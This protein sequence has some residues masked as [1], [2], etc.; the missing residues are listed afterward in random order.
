MGILHRPHRYDFG[1][2]YLHKTFPEKDQQLIERLLYI[3]DAESL[4]ERLLEAD[5]EFNKVS[6][7][8]RQMLEN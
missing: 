3:N 6:M 2:R 8:V 4:R 5:Q 7:Q 1:L